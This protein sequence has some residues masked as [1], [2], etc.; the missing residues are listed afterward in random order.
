MMRA[1]VK[2]DPDTGVVRGY[3]ECPVFFDDNGD[4]IP[5]DDVSSQGHLQ[6]EVPIGGSVRDTFSVDLATMQ[7]AVTPYVDTAPT[8][9]DDPQFIAAENARKATAAER[10][11]AHGGRIN[12][13]KR[14]NPK[15]QARG[16]KHAPDAPAEDVSKAGALYRGG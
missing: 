9:L 4:E 11:A 6:I 2:V 1:F 16:P 14:V 10:I 12:T 7:V 13:P 15:K 8:R 5:I 3:S